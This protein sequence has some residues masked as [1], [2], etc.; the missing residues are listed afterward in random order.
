MG[1][2][3]A[4]GVLLAER[5]ALRPKEAATAL[6]LSER[7]FRALLPE[8]PHVR[9]GGAVLVPIDSLR[10]WLR[11]RAEAATN[12]VD[13]AVGEILYDIGKQ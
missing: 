8:L 11:D 5:L 4:K 2:Q 13:V 1:E 9:V 10:E 3:P 6:G 12:R 7:A